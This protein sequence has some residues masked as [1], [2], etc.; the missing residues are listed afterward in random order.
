MKLVFRKVDVNHPEDIRQFDELM[1]D[2]SERA[3]DDHT[4]IERIT[5]FNSRE[6]AYL[7]VAEDAENGKL[8]GSL[9]GV[10]FSDFCGLCAPVMVI[11]NVVTHHAYRRKGVARAMMHEMEE[12]GKAHGVRY[13]T[14]CS[15]LNRTEAHQMYADLGYQ[16][17]RGFKKYLCG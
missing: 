14:L 1:D 15:A 10:I 6:D 9:I 12:W 7:M 13:V 4:L 2:I 11:E 16:E 3:Y 17:V 5:E 8:V